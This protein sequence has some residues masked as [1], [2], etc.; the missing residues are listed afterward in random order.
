MNIGQNIRQV[1]D[2][3]LTQVADPV[4]SFGDPSLSSLIENMIEILKSSHGV[5]IA[6]PQV[7][8]LMQVIIVASR[9]NL[10]Y[11]NAPK[12]DPLV[13]VNPTL[14]AASAEQAWGWEGCLSVP[15]QR[16]LVLRA[17]Q[18]EVEFLTQDG[19]LERV[20]WQD[21]PARIF[22]H[23]LDHLLG[24]VFLERDPQQLLSEEAYQSQ[25]VS[26]P[27]PLR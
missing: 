27:I 6:A 19:I 10:R 15:D 9:P 12:M 14:V 3:I 5:G 22:Q 13:M 17:Q 24:C 11:P 18:V 4:V 20:V 8:S 21:F 2:P 25:I 26:Q 7:G 1:G 16:G 23:E